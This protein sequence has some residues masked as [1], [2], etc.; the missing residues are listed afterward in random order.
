MKKQQH[1]SRASNHAK[2]ALIGFPNSGKSSLFNAF[3]GERS[4]DNDNFLFCT[5]ETTTCTIPVDDFR[6][7]WLNSQFDIKNYKSAMITIVDTPG[8]VQD[9]FK[10]EG[11][12]LS[13]FEEIRDV[14]VLVHVLRAFHDD[15]VTHFDELIDPVREMNIVNHEVMMSDLDR[16]EKAIQS[17]EP[18][19][20]N[21]QGGLEAKLER[22]TLIE[23]WEYLA[24][25]SR[26]FTLHPEETVTSPKKTYLPKKE[27]K[28]IPTFTMPTICSGYP[29]RLKHWTTRQIDLLE[30]Y[31]LLSAKPVIYMVNVAERDYLRSLATLSNPSGRENFK[32]RTVLDEVYA[33]ESRALGLGK[34]NAGATVTAASGILSV[35]SV[36][37]KDPKN[38]TDQGAALELI[39]STSAVLGTVSNLGSD[40]MLVPEDTIE[41]V[42]DA[43]DSSMVDINETAFRP[44]PGTLKVGEVDD[45]ASVGLVDIRTSLVICCSVHFE[46][47]LSKKSRQ[48]MGQQ[49]PSPWEEYTI[50]NPS[51]R[52]VLTV[53]VD[54]LYKT[55]GL[56]RFYSLDVRA[57]SSAVWLLRR[58][59]TL[60]LAGSTLHVNLSRAFIRGDVVNYDDLWSFYTNSEAQGQAVEPGLPGLL[61]ALDALR[62]DGLARSQGAKYLVNDG[63]IIDF[64]AHPH[65]VG[66]S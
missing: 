60:L 36:P 33:Y 27:S 9:S 61:A 45:N 2:C 46:D 26:P 6:L 42:D 55:L 39:N 8:I 14:D 40:S 32:V 30:K 15:D 35:D 43:S 3:Q 16:L 34:A 41:L 1:H 47:V 50:C 38:T 7:K 25:C 44:F 56:I 28:I 64:V 31:K 51:H 20:R 24:G 11:L 48:A 57:T 5:V 17:L 4:V 12:G 18:V 23:A 49:H 13:F 62:L 37:E 66:F 29:L 21:I 22:E 65:S 63:D 19:I 54:A 52:S 53:L 59:S 10:G 58:G